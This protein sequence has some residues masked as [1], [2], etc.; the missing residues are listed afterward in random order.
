MNF[1]TGN[2]QEDETN[3]ELTPL[4][5]VVFLL[6]IFF[7]ISTT[8]TK[9]TSLKINLPE[10]AGEQAAVEVR[11]VEI[12]I[13]EKSQYALAVDNDS[14][15]VLINSSRDTLI[16][17]LEPFK[18]EKKLLLIIRADQKA[19]HEAVIK[20]MDVAQELGLT[21]LTFATKKVAN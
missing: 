11:N 21:N 18:D 5:D 12:Q 3:I 13:S 17:A 15:K 1:G 7:M 10:S 20:V 16:R 4:I 9:E 2:N 8:F 19:P 14:A 6:L